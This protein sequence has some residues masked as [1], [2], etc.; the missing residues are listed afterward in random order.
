MGNGN[1]HLLA[2]FSNH[3]S[4]EELQSNSDAL[5][6]APF[7]KPQNPPTPFRSSYEKALSL[8][9]RKRQCPPLLN[10]GSREGTK[11]PT[12]W[13]NALSA[14]RSNYFFMLIS[15]NYGG[16]LSARR[17]RALVK[18][19]S[20]LTAIGLNFTV[21]KSGLRRSI[22]CNFVCFVAGA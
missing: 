10:Q 14:R 13:A 12:L 1:I 22:F 11:L 18:T 7:G 6:R 20:R 15:F 8:I 3:G 16:C 4:C 5:R 21:F 19:S 17:S 2:Y 9:C